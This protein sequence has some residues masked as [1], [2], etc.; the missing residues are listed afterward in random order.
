MKKLTKATKMSQVKV[1]DS[2]RWTN[3]NIVTALNVTKETVHFWSEAGTMRIVWL[4]K[5]NMTV[6]V[7]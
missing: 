2:F 5:E 3:G 1:G 4:S 6:N 7:R